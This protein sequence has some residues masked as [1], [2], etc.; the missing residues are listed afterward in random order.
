M[1]GEIPSSVER[2]GLCRGAE[3]V[4]WM[5]RVPLLPH[6]MPMELL[7]VVVQPHR[8]RNLVSLN[9]MVV[10]ALGRPCCE[11]DARYMYDSVL[12][13]PLPLPKSIPL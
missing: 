12:V 7:L 5:F 9:R 2:C 4:L 13:T 11:P 3:E 8:S 6:Q 1:S 10:P